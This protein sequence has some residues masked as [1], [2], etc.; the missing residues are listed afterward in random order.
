MRKARLMKDMAA[1]R[2]RTEV[3]AL[4][5]S[6]QKSKEASLCLYLIPDVTSLCYEL[7]HIRRLVAS[8]RFFVVIPTSGIAFNVWIYDVVLRNDDVIMEW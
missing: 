8:G 3:A 6:L 1:S 2:L 5:S 4:E 7:P